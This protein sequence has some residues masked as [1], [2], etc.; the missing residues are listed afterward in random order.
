MRAANSHPRGARPRE[1]LEVFHKLAPRRNVTSYG[2]TCVTG[3]TNGEPEPQERRRL[4]RSPRPEGSAS[5]G[6]LL[7]SESMPHSAQPIIEHHANQGRTRKEPGLFCCSTDSGIVRHRPE[8]QLFPWRSSHAQTS[9]RM[10][11]VC[12]KHGGLHGGLLPVGRLIDV[13]TSLKRTTR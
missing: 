1:S 4:H 7:L 10:H 13:Y 2:A 3:S 9:R 12:G 8:Q 11:S 5:W 6:I